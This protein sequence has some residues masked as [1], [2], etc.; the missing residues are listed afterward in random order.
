MSEEKPKRYVGADRPLIDRG[1]FRIP[2][3]CIQEGCRGKQEIGFSCRVHFREA[4]VEKMRGF[5]ARTFR[6]SE[7]QVREH[8]DAIVEYMVACFHQGGGF[9]ERVREVMRVM[10]EHPEFAAVLRAN[11]EPTPEER[12]ELAKRA[13]AER[14]IVRLAPNGT[15]G[16]DG[17][18]KI[19]S[20]DFMPNEPASPREPHAVLV[21]D[22]GGPDYTVRQRFML[23][24]VR[25]PGHVVLL[26]E[27][28]TKTQ[29]M[30]APVPEME[31][32]VLTPEEIAAKMAASFDCDAYA[33]PT[34]TGDPWMKGDPWTKGTL[35]LRRNDDGTWA[36]GF[37]REG[38]PLTE[39]LPTQEATITGWLESRP[40][41]YAPAPEGFVMV[42]FD[43][44]PPTSSM[45]L[46][47]VYLVPAGREAELR[48]KVKPPPRPDPGPLY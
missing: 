12:H 7:D 43:I 23:P 3:P 35:R 44:S 33:L 46:A 38:P 34:P 45:R 14:H 27:E 28:I 22:L 47:D 48:E 11:W 18:V 5:V 21:G 37:W 15:I 30:T 9:E 16:P 39:C 10:N 26:S 31:I 8:A 24:D 32:H 13:A 4:V 29:P 2:F 17:E 36:L 40:G 25:N 41:L 1:D 42:A 6:I 20:F 19:T